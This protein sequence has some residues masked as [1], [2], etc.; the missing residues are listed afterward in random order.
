MLSTLFLS[1]RSNFMNI[2][3][4]FKL[5]QLL[6]IYYLFLCFSQQQRNTK[7]VLFTTSCWWARRTPTPGQVTSSHAWPAHRNGL[8]VA[9]FS[10]LSTQPRSSLKSGFSKGTLMIPWST[11]SE[12]RVAQSG[13]TLCDPMDYTVH[14]ILQARILEWLAFPFSRGSSQNRSP[15][16]QADSLP[17]EPKGKPKN[18]GMGSLSLLWQIFPTQE[19][20]WGLLHCRR[21]LYQLSYEGSHVEACNSLK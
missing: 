3:N 17:A 13:P 21:I 10:V 9:F 4:N 18:T 20:N 1:L 2:F 15:A 5:S 14:G 7:Y 12:V 19:S 16:L 8:S 6:H 11:W